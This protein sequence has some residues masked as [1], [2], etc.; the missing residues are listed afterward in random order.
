[1]CWLPYRDQD[2][3]DLPYRGC[4]DEDGN[5]D[6]E[7]RGSDD[8]PEHLRR[9]FAD[10]ESDWDE[11]RNND[12]SRHTDSPVDLPANTENNNLNRM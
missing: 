1:M 4:W 7:A 8:P 3:N 11:D 5:R 2:G 9:P 10:Q 6:P 12:Y